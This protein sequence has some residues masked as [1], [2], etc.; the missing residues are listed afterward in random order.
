MGKALG[1]IRDSRR[2]G[3]LYDAE[4]YIKTFKQWHD[5]GQRRDASRE[6]EFVTATHVNA[7]FKYGCE[8]LH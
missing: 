2:Q 1:F 5:L 8:V 7:G 4:M 3:F 6:G